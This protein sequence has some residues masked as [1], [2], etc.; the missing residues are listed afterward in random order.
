M[1][2]NSVRDDVK[3]VIREILADYYHVDI[4]E[5][6]A[7]LVGSIADGVFDALAIKPEEQDYDREAGCFVWM[8]AP[9][10]EDCSQETPEDS[11]LQNVAFDLPIG[12]HT[13]E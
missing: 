4:L 10:E 8:N 13:K 11:I 5:V 6:D 1:D 12:P 9:M 7:D 2:A 3:D